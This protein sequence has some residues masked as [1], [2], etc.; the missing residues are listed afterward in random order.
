MLLLLV[1][2]AG[3]GW[4]YQANW[5]PQFA[6]LFVEA[7]PPVKAPRVIPVVTATVGQRD[8]QLYLNGLGTVTAL[9]TVTIRSRVEGELVNVSFV[10]GQMVREGD[11]LAEIDS[12]PFEVQRDQ[13]AGQ[14][15]RDEATLTAAKLTLDRLERLFKANSVSTQEV[16]NQFA[17]VQQTEGAIKSDRAMV[18]DAELQITYC[19]IV[20][21]IDGRIGLRLVDVGNV[22]RA[23]DPSGLAVINQLQP[24]A[25]T[26]TI[27]QDEI[28]RVRK[29]ML[30]GHELEV[31]AYDRDFTTKLASGKLLATDNQVDSAT[32]TLRLKAIIDQNAAALFPNQFVNTRLLVDT[33]PDAIVVP[34]AAV[35]RGPDSAFVYV[36]KSDDTVELRTVVPGPTEG[37]E[38]AIETGLALGEIVVTEGIDKLQ[39]NAK[40]S[41][42]SAKTKDAKHK[43]EGAKTA[44]ASPS[45]VKQAEVPKPQTPDGVVPGQADTSRKAR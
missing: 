20:S 2:G 40:V 42:R 8:L 13:A 45:D 32:G 12:R 29:R 35:Q 5:W 14:L 39:P 21:P 37:A 9:K 28:P 22:V 34:S 7:P 6:T 4:Y 26:F 43:T 10:E 1:A 41:R 38:T 36:V 11:L 27:S 18:A 33:M 3:A 31:D 30:E 24:I 17:I 16:E 44:A 23:N 25:L 19:K 15:A